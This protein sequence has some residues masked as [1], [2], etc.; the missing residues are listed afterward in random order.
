MRQPNSEL[1]VKWVFLLTVVSL[2]LTVSLGF[3]QF[4]RYQFRL[5]DLVYVILL[6]YMAVGIAYDM[7][8][9]LFVL[10]IRRHD[11]PRM[12][13][14]TNRPPVALVCCTC[15][16]VDIA[17]LNNLLN[18]TYPNLD[19]FVLDDSRS[20]EYRSLVDSSGLTVVRRESQAGYKAGNLNNWLFQ[21]G[22]DYQ[23]FVVA[24]ADSM[25]PGEFVRQMVR[26][27][28][29]PDNA[30]VAIFESHIYAWNTATEFARLQNVMTPLY[31][32]IK[33][34]L[35]NRLG[36]NLSVGH[37]NLYRTAVLMSIGGFVEDYLA[38][39]FATSAE[40]VRG[41]KRQCKTVP[42]V[43]YERLPQ[44]LS[45]FSKRQARWAFQTFQLLTLRN[46]LKI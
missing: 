27:A 21:Y 31:H 45:E 46:Y 18:Q 32:Q 42:V 2:Y 4:F 26:Y 37:N 12:S 30:D 9:L 25:F 1:V 43:S 29:H 23:Y 7:A 17:V 28:E 38:E 24:D 19:I 35:D 14:L 36:T 20:R 44:N 8:E 13:V 10:V 40:V 22:S 16:D 33:S 41:G 15:D 5:Q 39:D 11:P 3:F 6:E 34:R